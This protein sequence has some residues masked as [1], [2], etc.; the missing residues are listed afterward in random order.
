LS[1]VLL[2]HN[3]PAGLKGLLVGYEAKTAYE[4]GWSSL[5]NGQL[6]DAAEAA[7]FSVFMTGDKNIV[8][9]QALRGRALT[10]AVLT[11]THWPTLRQNADLILEALQGAQRGAYL[12]I[13]VPRMPLRRRPAPGRSNQP[14]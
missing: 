5:S 14:E 4:M 10:I 1:L 12:D 13:I 8:H 2:D 6:L 3:L 9:Q 7:G 11:E